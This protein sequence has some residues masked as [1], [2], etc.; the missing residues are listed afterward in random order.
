MTPIRTTLQPDRV[1]EVDAAEYADLAR[2]GL[3]LTD[4]QPPADDPPPADQTPDMT[5]GQA[6]TSTDQQEA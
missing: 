1:I 2:Q 4:E 5:G 3:L 6:G